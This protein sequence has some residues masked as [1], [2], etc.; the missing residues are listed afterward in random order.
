MNK[1]LLLALT[2]GGLIAPLSSSAQ[3]VNYWGVGAVRSGVTT[4]TS[5]TTSRERTNS[6]EQI[7]SGSVY[8]V[9]GE[10]ITA[11]GNGNLGIGQTY[12]VASPGSPFQFSETYQPSGL[13]QITTFGREVDTTTNTNSLSVFSEIQ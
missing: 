10:N 2:L 4:G 8:T 1:R 13:T 5:V 6:L 12:N 3:I 7:Y 11:N 9:S